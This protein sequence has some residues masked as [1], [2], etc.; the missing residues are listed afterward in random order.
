[1]ASNHWLTYMSIGCPVLL[2]N[3]APNQEQGGDSHYTTV[4]EEDI[5]QTSTFTYNVHVNEQHICNRLRFRFH[6]CVP[7]PTGMTTE[8]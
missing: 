6:V 2:I 5:S 8:L 3:L 4:P 1:M 7:V